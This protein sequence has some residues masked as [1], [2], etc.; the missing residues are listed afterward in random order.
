MKIYHPDAG[1]FVPYEVIDGVYADENEKER[2]IDQEFANHCSN[3]FLE[4][5]PIK[6]FKVKTEMTTYKCKECGS[7]KFYVGRYEWSTYVKCAKCGIEE[8][9][10]DG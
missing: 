8:C 9:V 7:S 10:H 4:R 1:V 6:Q 2:P 3:G 5:R